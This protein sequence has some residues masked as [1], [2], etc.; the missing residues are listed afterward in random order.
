[1]EYTA[2]VR[3]SSS[4]FSSSDLGFLSWDAQRLGSSLSL[5]PVELTIAVSR[6]SPSVAA[7]RL[8]PVATLHTFLSSK[9]MKPKDLFRSH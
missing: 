6:R 1:M 4:H 5:D 2:D 9:S 3:G 8:C 7:C